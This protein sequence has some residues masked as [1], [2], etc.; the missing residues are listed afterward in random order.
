MSVVRVP[1]CSVCKKPYNWLLIEY[2]KPHKAIRCFCKHEL[3]KDHQKQP[4]VDILVEVEV[5]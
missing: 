3:R 2:R 5:K 1:W 4:I